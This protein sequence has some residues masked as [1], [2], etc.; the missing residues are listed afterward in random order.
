M[1]R[2]FVALFVVVAV[3]SLLVGCSSLTG[4][5]G[6]ETLVRLNEGNF[7]V[8]KTNIRGESTGF[9]LLAGFVPIV[10]ATYTQALNNLH[11]AADM[12]GKP[13]ALVNVAQDATQLNLLLFAIPRVTITADVVEFTQ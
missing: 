1:N 13:A 6:L 9:S 8:V 11:E 12:E 7:R 2:R 3:S 4:R 5:F 10:P